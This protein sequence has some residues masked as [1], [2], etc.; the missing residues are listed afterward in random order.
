M[1]TTTKKEE[2]SSIFWRTV[3]HI[4]LLQQNIK[5]NHKKL[6]Y[7]YG[8]VSLYLTQ[9]QPKCKIWQVFLLLK[10]QKVSDSYFLLLLG[11]TNMQFNQSKC[12]LET[13]WKIKNKPTT[14]NY[15]CSDCRYE[16]PIDLLI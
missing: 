13:R 2:G 8:I 12:D 7:I 11:D 3:Q 6:C 9:L 10:Y 14:H 16:Y 4:F 5:N 1:D 15:I